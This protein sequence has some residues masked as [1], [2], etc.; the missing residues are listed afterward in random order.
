MSTQRLA[1]AA[2]LSLLALLA[3]AP[4]AAQ[5]QP[6]ATG[7]GLTLQQAVAT[8]R[9]NNPDMQAQR[10]DTRATQAAI[11]NARADFLPSADISAGFGYTGSGEQRFGSQ[12][13]GEKPVYYSSDWSLGL[14]YQ[15]SGAKMLQPRIARA[16]HQVAESRIADFEAELVM[17]VRQQYLTTL[18]AGELATQA[19]REVERTLEHERLARAKLEVGSGT[20]LDVRR[21]QVER[22]RAEVGVV[23]QQNTYETELLRLGMLMGVD[24]STTTRLESGFELFEPRWS[25]DELVRTALENNPG[26]LAARASTGA[27][28]TQVRAARSAYLP[29]LSFRVG[30]TGSVYSAGDIDP[31]VQQ[32]LGGMQSAFASCTEGNAIRAAVGL[33]PE[34]CSQFNVDDPVVQAAVRRQVEAGNPNFPF[35]YQQQPLQASMSISLPLFDG[36]N[37]ERRIEE[38]RVQESDARY[39]VRTEELRLTRDV[40]T[41]LLN[42]QTAYRTAQLQRQVAENAAEELRMARERFRLGAASSIEVTDAQ[43]R[44]AE[45]ERAVIDAVYA[46]HK[47]VAALEALVG[48][49]LR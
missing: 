27:A 1:R 47:S 3:A 48:R 36:L 39:A 42:A 34:N 29:S 41:G 40:R 13:F 22:G 25:G 24:L 45:A 7:P 28:E 43:T 35:G 31:L 2:G 32:Q 21:A 8:A 4:L 33:T 5:Q 17:Q 37:R 12:T 46:Y 6:A 15:L 38:A 30:L 20:P 49:S 14:N 44:L 23:Q 26:L 16:Q 11:R 10:N 9:Q 19:Q 18:Q